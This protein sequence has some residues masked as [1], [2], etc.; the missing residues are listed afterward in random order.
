MKIKREKL[1][2]QSNSEV[3][4]TGHR[5]VNGSYT[6]SHSE[7]EKSVTQHLTTPSKRAA[8]SINSATSAAK[9]KKLDAGQRVGVINSES[10]TNKVDT[11]S[12]MAAGS[13][14]T[15]DTDSRSVR[16]ALSQLLFHTNLLLLRVSNSVEP[17]LN[18]FDL[19]STFF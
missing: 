6:T 12:P 2:E 1:R 14:G 16:I 10:K 8:E 11:E 17:F 7:Q 3:D 18:L 9:L 5:L 4:G 15:S 19:S 13:T